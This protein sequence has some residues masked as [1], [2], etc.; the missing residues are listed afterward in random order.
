ML[1]ISN[2]M[3]NVMIQHSCEIKQ[4]M[5]YLVCSLTKTFC[6]CFVCSLLSRH[7]WPPV[8]ETA[9]Q[10]FY[11]YEKNGENTT[12]PWS[13]TVDLI[14]LFTWTVNQQ[15][16]SEAATEGVCFNLLSCFFI[17]NRSRVGLQVQFLEFLCGFCRFC[18]CTC[19][20]SFTDQKHTF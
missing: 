20:F 3:S 17:R 5:G 18:L 10:I 19:G 6:F 2:K 7:S 16:V 4:D 13:D 11:G 1:S 15:L 14:D 8:T 9:G 12:M